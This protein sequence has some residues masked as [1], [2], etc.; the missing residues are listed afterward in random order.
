MSPTKPKRRKQ[1]ARLRPR[2]EV[3][4]AV[5]AAVSIVV[6]TLLLIWALRPATPG[7]PGT[8]GIITRQPRFFVWLV[9]C[10][11]VIAGVIM[12]LLR[13]R[14]RPRRWPP[15]VTIPVA[16]GILVLGSILAGIFWPGGLIKDY[17]SR[18]AVPDIEDLET[19]VPVDPNPTVGSTPDGS[20]TP[21]STTPG[22]T[23]TPTTSG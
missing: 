15:K 18:P 23:S 14:R 10:G 11:S 5:V 22:S 13:G 4:V 3:V 21:G 8:G 17:P 20:T 7:V 19:S 6:A 12:W 2:S 16:V 9:V 1:T